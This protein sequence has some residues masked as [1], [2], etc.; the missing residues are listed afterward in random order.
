MLRVTVERAAHYF[1]YRLPLHTF[2]FPFECSRALEY[3][4]IFL[5]ICELL[6][7]AFREFFGALFWSRTG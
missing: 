5:K 7:A 6:F 4:E 2:D 3:N 1:L